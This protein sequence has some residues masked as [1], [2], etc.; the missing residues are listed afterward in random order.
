MAAAERHFRAMGGEAHVLIVGGPAN[1]LDAAE[2]RIAD[3][4]ARWSRFRKDSELSMLNTMPEMPVVVSR[5]TFELIDKAVF[6]W[7][8]TRGRFDPTVMVSAL[9][10]DRSFDG[11]PGT[12]SIGRYQSS[13]GCGRIELDRANLAITLPSGVT[14]DPGG[15]GKGLGADIVAREVLAAGATG[16]MVNL[17]G[18]LRVAGESPQRDGW[19]V[20]IESPFDAGTELARIHLSDGAVATSSRLERRWQRD[21][22]DYHHLVDPET[23]LPFAGDIAAVSVV[24]GKAWWAEAM[25]KAVFAVGADKAAAALENATALVVD[26][27]GRCVRT[28]GFAEVAA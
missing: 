11:M 16:V 8:Q 3:L 10:Y 2:G 5:E 28:P 7:R 24:A 19:T 17:G 15:I 25:T 12:G 26:V 27:S 1:L 9:G 22:V 6:A 4:E 23:G 21:G 13:P 20:L 18:D 14:I